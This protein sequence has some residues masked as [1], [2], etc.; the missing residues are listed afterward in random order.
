MADAS[1]KGK[2][3]KAR[4]RYGDYCLTVRGEMFAAVNLPIGNGKYKQKRKKVANATEARQWAL[5]ELDKVKHGTIEVTRSTT[6]AELAAWYKR[7]FL[8]AP[9][10]ENG[11][12]LDG[13]KDHKKLRAKLDRVVEFFG[14]RQASGFTEHDF[15][16]YAR[17]RR[18]ADSV[19]TATINRDLSLIRSMF[20]RAKSV[21][22]LLHVPRFPINIAAEA[23]RDRVLSFDEETR[24]LAHC[25]DT[26]V[27][28]YERRGKKHTGVEIEAKRAHLAGIIIM[29]VDTAMRSGEIFKLDWRDVDLANDLITVQF[30]NSK[31]Q[32]TRRIGMTP[33]VKAIL[34]EKA[35]LD[36]TTGKVFNAKNAS[37]AF[38]T[39]CVRANITD[40]HFHDLRHTATTRMIRAGIP[41]TEV[42]KI[43]G[44]TQIKTFLRYLNLGSE[45]VQNAASRLGRFIDDVITETDAV[46]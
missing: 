38:R 27:V 17:H 36:D 24:L 39:A 29:A 22:K 34:L 21:N 32:K 20:L 40:L 10:F 31:T 14:G 19:T 46:N 13:V 12:K 25:V 3:K 30:F 44:H 9:V 2:K 7:E 42:M 11:I 28:E 23:E 16:A 35:A 1:R 15:T 8:I 37:R 33:R 5:A 41:H 18:K 26:E 43:T 4:N 45:T 6:F